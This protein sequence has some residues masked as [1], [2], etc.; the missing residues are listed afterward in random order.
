MWAVG[1]GGGRSVLA[2]QVSMGW[3]TTVELLHCCSDQ[4]CACSSWFARGGQQGKA[5]SWAGCWSESTVWRARLG[6]AARSCFSRKLLLPY[7]RR[8]VRV[9]GYRGRSNCEVRE[10]AR[11]APSQLLCSRAATPTHQYKSVN[12]RN[13]RSIPATAFADPGCSAVRALAVLE[14]CS[15]WRRVPDADPC[16]SRRRRLRPRRWR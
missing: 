9:R 13:E 15:P 6:L 16:P 5:A 10:A 7:L 8:E 4:R 1:R 3:E 12:R 14:C 2:R 11:L